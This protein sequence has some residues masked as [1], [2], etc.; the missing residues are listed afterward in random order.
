MSGS[1]TGRAV[2]VES[3]PAGGGS[4]LGKDSWLVLAQ[5]KRSRWC[6]CRWAPAGFTSS[7]ASGGGPA[8]G[9]GSSEPP[10]RPPQRAQ[11]SSR[12][13]G[14]GLPAVSLVLTLILYVYMHKLHLVTKAL[15]RKLGSRPGRRDLYTCLCAGEAAGPR[16]SAAS[17]TCCL[18]PERRA[19]T[20]CAAFGR[21]TAECGV[22]VGRGPTAGASARGEAR[23]GTGFPGKPANKG[24]LCPA[25]G[26][27]RP[28]DPGGRRVPAWPPNGGQVA[29]AGLRGA[30]G[31]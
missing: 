7:A 16:V 24:A 28:R 17:V 26:R 22:S 20:A 21:G 25:A 6:A 30:G 11:H 14:E 23:V 4:G 10:P 27:S 15:P 12:F 31:L 9:D 19:R 2:A 13:F 29:P 8:P 3:R 1:S 18:R 5:K